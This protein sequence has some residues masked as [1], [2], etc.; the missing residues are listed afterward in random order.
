MKFGRFFFFAL[1]FSLISGCASESSLKNKISEKS[2]FYIS[3]YKEYKKGSFSSK[4]ELVEK[5]MKGSV[6]LDNTHVIYIPDKNFQDGEDYFV[7]KI[8]KKEAVYITVT[9]KK[10]GEKNVKIFYFGI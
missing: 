1:F 5:S 3:I 4:F 2:D 9:I 10:S 6:I 7:V 8:S